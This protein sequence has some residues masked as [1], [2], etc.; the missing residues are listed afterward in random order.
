MNE[1]LHECQPA[2]WFARKNT[3]LIAVAVMFVTVLI[4][5]AGIFI[6]Y[7]R[8]QRIAKEIESVGGIV[9]RKF[10]GPN[11]I[12]MLIP[13]RFDFWD[14]ITEVYLS[15]SRVT[16]TGLK[17]LEG[18]WNLNELYLLNTQ[19]SDAGLEH[20]KGLT[21]L[22]HL[23]LDSTLTTDVGLE[24]LNGLTSL[25][26]LDLDSTHTT[27]VGLEHLKGLKNLVVLDLAETQTTIEG[28]GRLRTALP[29]CQITPDP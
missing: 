10:L 5:A 29:K 15:H 19:I 6:P 24:H 20:L 22:R 23:D 3:V 4:G 25:R 8:E 17:D 14:R 18:L 12:P 2:W 11:W 9:E 21:S 28:R 13:D 16:D 7:Q 27:D 26:H 1:T